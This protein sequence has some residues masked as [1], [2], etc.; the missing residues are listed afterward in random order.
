MQA[1]APIV[2]PEPDPCTS[3]RRFTLRLLRRD[4][5]GLRVNL[6]G[7]RVRYVVRLRVRLRGGRTT[8]ASARYRTC[9]AGSL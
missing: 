4:L 9:R 5:P 2:R 3:R 7:A 1:A 6:E 8:T